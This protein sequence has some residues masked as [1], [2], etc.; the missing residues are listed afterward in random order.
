MAQAGEKMWYGWPELPDHNPESTMTTSKRNNFAVDLA[1]LERKLAS[2]ITSTFSSHVDTRWNPPATQHNQSATKISTPNIAV[3]SNITHA[4]TITHGVTKSTP[5]AMLQLDGVL[6][7]EQ[8]NAHASPVASIVTPQRKNAVYENQLQ[9][10]YVVL[11]G[12]HQN[13]PGDVAVIPHRDNTLKNGSKIERVKCIYR[14]HKNLHD[15]D[16]DDIIKE[17][18]TSTV[19]M[20]V[21]LSN[22]LITL[23]DGRFTAALASNTS[24]QKI[25]LWDNKI[26][27]EGVRSLASALKVNNTL[28]CINLYGN[29]ISKVGAQFLSEALMVN[30]SLDNMNLHSNSIGEDGVQSLATALQVNSTLKSINLSGNQICAVGTKV[31]AK[32]LMANIMLED[33]NLNNNMIGDEGAQSLGDALKV[34]NNLR[35]IILSGN[36]I[37]KVGAKCSAEALMVNTKLEDMNLSTNSIGDEGAQ[38]LCAVLQVNKSDK[39]NRCKVLSECIDGQY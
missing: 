2:N 30:T 26:G 27:D 14:S 35:C 22:N 15:E 33:L 28:R 25:N 13:T 23:A 37:S 16:L 21:N 3:A 18:E 19:L 39:L 31:L 8:H 34:N 7:G 29:T 20:E 10:H 38:I 1:G 24:L 32:T 17:L 6:L 11:A 4:P 5:Q 36:Q 9:H 12:E